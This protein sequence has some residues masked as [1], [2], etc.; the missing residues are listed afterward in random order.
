[1]SSKERLMKTFDALPAIR[2]STW[3]PTYLYLLQA[4][5]WKVKIWKISALI[6]TDYAVSTSSKPFYAAAT[7]EKRDL[8][9]H[10]ILEDFPSP[11]A[12]VIRL[13]SP[14]FS[15]S[16]DSASHVPGFSP[17]VLGY[18][19]IFSKRSVFSH[20]LFTLSLFWNAQS[21]SYRPDSLTGK[22]EVLPLFSL[23]PDG[24]VTGR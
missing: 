14:I 1:M 21:A 19:S 10:P 24:W 23:T 3:A 16:Q 20:D 17:C 18:V 11:L 8:F 5:C 2:Y 4:K 6:G 15:T 22:I 7:H 9:L 13:S 12:C